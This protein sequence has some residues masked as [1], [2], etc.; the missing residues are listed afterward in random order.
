MMGVLRL[1]NVKTRKIGYEMKILRLDI[2]LTPIEEEKNRLRSLDHVY[3]ETRIFSSE[4][5][6]NPN[7]Y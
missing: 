5:G 2:T 1:M 7:N 6:R 4:E 3:E